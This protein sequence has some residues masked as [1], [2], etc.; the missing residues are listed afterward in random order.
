MQET[1][2]QY[3]HVTL[4]FFKSL[5]LALPW[6]CPVLVRLFWTIKRPCKLFQNT[7]SF[8][9]TN[10][11]WINNTFVFV[12]G[13]IRHMTAAQPL[14]ITSWGRKKDC[15]I[16]QRSLSISDSDIYS[17]RYHRIYTDNVSIGRERRTLFG[18][19][20]ILCTVE[21]SQCNLHLCN[22]RYVEFK[23]L[24]FQAFL[25]IILHPSDATDVKCGIII[26]YEWHVVSFMPE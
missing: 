6:Q 7:K 14:L 18:M 21:G 12:H 25:I 8:L 11:V 2:N 15:Q 24:K 20:I 1:V 10:V 3:I 16:P 22:Q 17:T 26:Y 23:L 4:I 9:T 5:L 13:L 19:A